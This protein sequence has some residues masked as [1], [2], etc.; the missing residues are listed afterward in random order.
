[1][2]FGK[3]RGKPMVNVPAPYLLWL[4]NSGCDHEQVRKYIAENLDSLNK[5][6]GHTKR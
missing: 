2:P 5:E 3:H 6:A 1:M 4:Y